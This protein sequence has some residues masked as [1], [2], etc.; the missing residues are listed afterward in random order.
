MACGNFSFRTR[1]TYLQDQEQERPHE[2]A[3]HPHRF[4]YCP[5]GEY[6]GGS[7]GLLFAWHDPGPQHL[8]S[9]LAHRLRWRF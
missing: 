1:E 3:A 9:L 6:T 5:K 7:L 4:L 2:I 8:D